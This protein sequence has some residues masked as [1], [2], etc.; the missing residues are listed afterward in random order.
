ML[1]RQAYRL[2]AVVIAVAVVASVGAAIWAGAG[3][4]A[5]STAGEAVIGIAVFLTV[6]LAG[7]LM[8]AMFVSDRTGQDR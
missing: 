5:V 8:T 7:G 3:E 4:D 6:L 2:I 1:D